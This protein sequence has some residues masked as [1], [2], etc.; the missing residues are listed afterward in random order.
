MNKKRLFAAMGLMA[1]TLGT[2]ALTRS[3][4]G[5]VTTPEM[6]A[7]VV[8]AEPVAAKGP[9]EPT[10][11]SVK[12]NYQ[13]PEWFRDAKFGIFMHWGLYAVPA[14]FSEWYGKH[15]YGNAGIT[16]WHTEKY[17]PP[18]KFGYKDFIPMF[19]AEKFDPDAWATLFKKS[20]AKYIVPTAMHHDGYALWDSKVVPWNTM[21][22]G[23][24]RDLIG[25]LGA[26]ARKQGLKFGVSHHGIEHFTF[27]QP[28]KGLVSDLQD[29]KWADFYSVA[30][31][32]D[33][34]LE[35][36]LKGWVAENF[37]LIEK[38]QPDMLWYDNGVNGRVFD[39]MKLKVA[40]HYYN[41]AIEWKKQVSISTKGHDAA[42]GPAYLA[43]SIM[44]FERSG[45]A[46]KQLVDYIWQVDE[47]VLRRFGYTNDPMNAKS[48]NVIRLLIDCT[49]KNGALLLNI[50]PRADGTIPDEQQKL[51]LEIGAWLEVNG[52]AIYGTRPWTQP[53]DGPARFTTKGDTLYATF[54]SSEVNEEVTV[55]ALAT[56]KVEGKVTDVSLV[57][58]GKLT[59]N[60]TDAGLQIEL[61]AETPTIYPAVKISGLKLK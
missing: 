51:L 17:G 58:G 46:P 33:A 13:T 61:P 21:A 11:E 3:Q 25:D 45:R 32:S 41:R 52:E 28:T 4:S 37:E 31:R 24:K 20:G 23:P 26:A 40:Q 27:I 16:K 9:F 12:A 59:F 6:V 44:D 49:S 34:A 15:M 47:P 14:Q 60:Q 55:K 22:M 10:W 2:P 5:P 38:Y 30:D 42:E 54:V 7:K 19:T 48:P 57:G 35:K 18:D 29:P 53:S 43:G 8:A 36:F 1:G 56:G 50:S 39:P